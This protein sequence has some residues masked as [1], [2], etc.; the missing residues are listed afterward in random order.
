MNDRFEIPNLLAWN[1]ALCRYS[2]SPTLV[3]GP[4]RA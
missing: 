3:E 4:L 1:A 2:R